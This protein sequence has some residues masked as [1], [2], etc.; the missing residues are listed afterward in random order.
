VERVACLALAFATGVLLLASCGGKAA[1]RSS[2]AT[3]STQAATE[4]HQA[5]IYLILE[6]DAGSPPAGSSMDDAL[7][8]V[9]DI[10]EKRLNAFGVSESEIEREGSNRLGVQLA[11]ISQQDARDLIGRTALLEFREPERDG[12]GNIVCTDASG[13][14]FTVPGDTVPDPIGD[15]RAAYIVTDAR[16]DL[17]QCQ[18]PNDTAPTGSVVWIPA[19]GVGNDNVEKAL[20]GRFLEANTG[21]IFDQ[22]GQP[23]VQL[24][25]NSEG[26]RLFDQITGRLVGFPMA[27]YL[28]EEIVSAPTILTRISGGKSV[29]SG[30]TADEGRKL[31]IQLNSGALPLPVRIIAAGEG[32]LP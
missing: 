8:G 4:T 20:T 31:A 5:T 15:R 17:T 23:L 30:L 7:K 2:T 13:K 25:F 11:G 16:R 22:L 19:T 10:I 21:V 6:V 32:P 1:D 3:V 12:S 26:G 18:G 14:Q 27:I 9:Q 28:D 24:Q 29:I